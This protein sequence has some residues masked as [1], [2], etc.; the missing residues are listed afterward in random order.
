MVVGNSRTHAGKE[1]AEFKEQLTVMLI[2]MLFVL[3]VADVRIRDVVALGWPGLA[4]A[5][6]LIV[7]VRPLSVL[8]GTLRTDLGVKERVFIGWI[9]PR[10]IIAAAVASLFGTSW[11]PRGSRAGARCAR[12]CS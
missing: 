1:L 10:G 12:S 7:L 9:G 8:L 6:C 3:L 5:A 2:G 11:R 4:V